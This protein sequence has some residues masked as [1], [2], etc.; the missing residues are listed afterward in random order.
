MNFTFGCDPE[1]MLQK[2][3][4]ICSAIGI[5]KGDKENKLKVNNCEFYYDNVLGECTVPPAS[6]KEEAISNI[7]NCLDTFFNVVSPYELIIK[8]SH[9]YDQDQLR[10]KDALKVYCVSENC[11]YLMEEMEPDTRIFHKTN[12]RSAGGHIHLG[13]DFLKKG[14]NSWTAAR[15]M[16]LFAGIPSIFLDN[17]P[18]SKKRKEIYGKSGR[19]RFTSYGIEYRSLS[20]FWLAS[21][22]L[23]ELFYD[24]SE[25]VLSIIE[26]EKY[27]ELWFIDEDKLKDNNMWS[28][29][30]FDSAKC[31]QAKY[32]VLVLKKAIDTC[33]KDLAK[34][35]LDLIKKYLPKQTYSKIEELSGSEFDFKKEWNIR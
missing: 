27:K 18:S 14:Y 26:T 23:V 19:F 4:E 22:K 10:H 20:N 24:I 21:P 9:K 5:L 15:L 32:N 30:K 11:C 25:T 6:T 2:N 13:A 28:D 17:D 35:Y 8:A 16:D 7:K 29:P 3:G 34:E 33:N 1:F 31:H 12:L